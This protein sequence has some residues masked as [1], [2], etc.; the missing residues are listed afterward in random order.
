MLEGLIPLEDLP[1]TPNWALVCPPGE[2]R[3]ACDLIAPIYP[4][5][6][7]E[8][9]Q[10]A[11]EVWTA[12]PRTSL[13]D[14]GTEKRWVTFDQR[15]ALFGFVDTIVAAFVDL[16]EGGASF[17]LYSYSNLGYWDLGVNRKRAKRWIELLAPAN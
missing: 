15:S 17:Y 14:G 7:E 5:T 11:I 3:E 1:S 12:E 4:G 6:P 16:G 2:E 8:L 10:R 9:A 13:T